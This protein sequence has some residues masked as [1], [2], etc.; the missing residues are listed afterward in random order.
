MSRRSGRS[1]RCSSVKRPSPEAKRPCAAPHRQLSKQAIQMKT[2]FNKHV[3]IVDGYSTG[4][5]L[6]RELSRRGVMCLHVR[7]TARIPAAVGNCFDA[8]AYYKDLGYLGPVTE[9]ATALQIISP[10]AVVAGSEWGVTFA[11]FVAQD[12]G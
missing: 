1:A 5:E 12:L 9:A 4:R 8:S 11:E 3:V 2:Q 7:S 6:V 10:D